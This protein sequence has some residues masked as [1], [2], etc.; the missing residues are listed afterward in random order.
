MKSAASIPAISQ[1]LLALFSRYAGWYLRRH[2]HSIRL[3]ASAPPPNDPPRPLIV[4]LNHAAWWDPLVCLLLRSEFFSERAAYAPIDTAALERYR[5]LKRLGFFP[6]ESGT[7]RGAGQFLKTSAA[8]LAEE[9][10]ALFVTPQGA[11]AD[12]RAP[13]VFARG[14]EHL[15]ARVPGARLVPL[16]IEYSFWEERQ[17]EILLAFGEAQSAAVGGSPVQRLAHLQAQLSAA[18]MRR[19]PN[20]W[21]ILRRGR[22]GVSRPYDFARWLGARLRGENFR[23]EHG[24]L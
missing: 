19:A 17:P 10:S 5:F 16:A 6:V 9:E 12:V 4:F 14:L 2:F 18:A 8:I 3:L 1:P 21:R 20:D 22:A 23:A 11:F 7:A 15:V 24:R 13:L